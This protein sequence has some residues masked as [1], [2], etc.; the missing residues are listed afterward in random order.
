MNLTESKVF[1]GILVISLGL[2][3]LIKEVATI[4]DA[5]GLFVAIFFTL[6]GFAFFTM[7]GYSHKNEIISYLVVFL[8]GLSLLTLEFNILPFDTLNVI[9]LLALSV[10]LSYLIYGSV[11]KFSIKAIWTGIIFTA[12]AL[13]IFLPKALAIEDIFWFS[14]KRYI[15]PI[16]LI[17]GGIFIILPTRRKE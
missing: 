6:I 16:L 14:V 15:I 3:L 11:V 12:I 1:S 8:F 13:L 5:F 2:T 9:F 17:V 4:H 10:G 7:R